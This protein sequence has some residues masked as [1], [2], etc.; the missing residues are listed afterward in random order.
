M[1]PRPGKLFLLR[2]SVKITI[3]C[4]PICGTGWINCAVHTHTDFARIG[5]RKGTLRLLGERV[6]TCDWKRNLIP[7]DTRPSLPVPFETESTSTRL[8]KPIDWKRRILSKSDQQER[9][10]G[11]NVERRKFLIRVPQAHIIPFFDFFWYH[12]N[13]LQYISL[14]RTLSIYA[15]NKSIHNQINPQNARAYIHLRKIFRTDAIESSQQ[16][17]PAFSTQQSMLDFRKLWSTAYRAVS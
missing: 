9:V 3:S 15:M 13:A 11:M 16:N 14:L 1:E 2:C 7:Q 6:A 10:N 8:S 12:R 17:S 4:Q 5:I